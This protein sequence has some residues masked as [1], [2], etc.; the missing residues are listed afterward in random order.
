MIYRKFIY[1]KYMNFAYKNVHIIF[2]VMLKKIPFL[3]FFVSPQ[4]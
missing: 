3:H 1:E 4:L 2:T